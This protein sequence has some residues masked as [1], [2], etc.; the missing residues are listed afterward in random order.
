MTIQ[1]IEK[2]SKSY[3]QRYQRSN[4]LGSERHEEITKEFL[5][6][7]EEV[8]KSILDYMYECN[9]EEMTMKFFGQASKAVNK[10]IESISC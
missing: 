7:I 5:K 2:K 4:R 6:F 8:S 9:D 10:V 1:E 3:I